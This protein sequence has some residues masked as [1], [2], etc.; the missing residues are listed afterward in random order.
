[1]SHY[2]EEGA[3]LDSVYDQW[4]LN[5]VAI[6]IVFCSKEASFQCSILKYS[7]PKIIILSWRDIEIDVHLKYI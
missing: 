1:M 7:R 6:T 3:W 4:I 5:F 2:C